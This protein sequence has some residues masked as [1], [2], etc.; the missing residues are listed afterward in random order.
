MNIL[1]TPFSDLYI[2]EPRIFTDERG[3]F[4]ESF[5][6]QALTKAGISTVFVQDNQSLSAANVLRG[7]HFQ[8]PPYAQDK[9]IRVIQG[10]VLDVVVDIRTASPTY[11]QSFS[12]QLSAANQLQLL[13][14]QGFAHGFLSLEPHTIF[15][16]KCSN[17]YHQPSE[18]G[19][20]YNDPALNIDWNTSNPILSPKD[21]VFQAFTDFKSPF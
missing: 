3:Y 18:G 11:G 16:Y 5:S 15:A 6:Q 7:L 21:L 13:I 4:F 20:L 17:Y 19:L 9:L 1:S 2:I 14:P 8:A 12:V 10:S